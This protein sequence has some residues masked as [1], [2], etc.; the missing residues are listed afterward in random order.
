MTITQDLRF[1]LRT[2]GKSPGFTALAVLTLGL[3]IGANVAIFSAVDAVLF[4]PLAVHDPEG[5]V[6]V[7]ATDDKGKDLF[8]HSYLVYTDYR[9]GATA[10]SG[11]AAFADAEAVHL[12]TGGMP[13][14]LTGALLDRLTHHVHILEMNGE[15]F[16][17]KDS[18]RRRPGKPRS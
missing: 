6:R 11:L 2:L 3:G 4:R 17:L 14:R 15:S 7:Y 9:D 5:L 10:F 18:K 1:G 12:S 8:N 13:E 16:R